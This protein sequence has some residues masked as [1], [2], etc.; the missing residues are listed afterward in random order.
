M[1]TAEK[2]KKLVELFEADSDLTSASSQ[3]GFGFLMEGEVP[4]FERIPE[5]RWG[6]RIIHPL[7]L[8]V[9]HWGGRGL[10]VY[11]SLKLTPLVGDR[12]E[13]GYKPGF[14]YWVP[15]KGSPVVVKRYLQPSDYADDASLEA[16]IQEMLRE[17]ARIYLLYCQEWESKG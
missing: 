12:S 13:L 16:V 3:T 11:L 9:T 14:E 4:K 8:Y 1:I 10:Q 5:D 15:G 6:P 2:V 7:Y 17:C